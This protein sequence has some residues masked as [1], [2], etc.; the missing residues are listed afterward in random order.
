MLV[1]SWDT[2]FFFISFWHIS[3]PL[4]KFKNL[5]EY[6]L[7]E[8]PKIKIVINAL[9]IETMEVSTIVKSLY[10]FNE[11]I[12]NYYWSLYL[13]KKVRVIHI[14]LKTIQIIII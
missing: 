13:Y 10:I 6:F 3:Y 7:S 14:L 1:V 2:I 11:N 4:E 12:V 9:L 5:N 8:I